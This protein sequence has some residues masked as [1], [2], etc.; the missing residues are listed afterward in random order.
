MFKTAKD[1]M[2]FTKAKMPKGKDAGK[3]TDEETAA[4][5]AWILSKNNVTV[6]KKV[7]ADS[8]AAINL[9]HAAPAEKAAA[10]EKPAGEEGAA[11]KPAK[12][13]AKK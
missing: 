9:P 8:A 7:D 11:K 12:T 2:D 1:L 13:P 6:E 3:L 4:L 10:G 5:T